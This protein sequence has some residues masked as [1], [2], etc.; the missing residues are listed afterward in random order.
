MTNLDL[1]Q[2]F[3]ALSDVVVN[4]PP[5]LREFDQIYMKISDMLL[6]AELVS[7][8]VD[9]KSIVCIGD[10][11]AIGLTLTHLMSEGIF[12][13]GP[14]HVHVLDFDER[15]VNSVETFAKNYQL[16]D[17]ITAELYNVADP[18][19][20]THIGKFDAFYTNPPFG[21]SNGGRSVE[22]FLQRGNEALAYRGMG[23]LVAATVN[24]SLPWTTQVMNR[25][26]MYLLENGYTMAEIV[27]QFHHY[28]LDDNPDLT[29]CSLIAV[30]DPKAGV[31]LTSAPLPTE[32]YQDFYGAC[33]P[34][35]V[36]YVRQV[37]EDCN[38][39]PYGHCFE[40]L[41]VGGTDDK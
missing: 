22:A 37:P 10:G 25:V 26:Q 7:R 38:S 27:P 13:R 17:S 39:P 20:K 31:H 16:Q 36:R 33:S 12:E 3:N 29:S 9:G 23:C 30:R 21:A 8:W 5:P 2:A 35:R 15:I 24:P 1:R 6:Q 40:F 19:P 11:D 34:L 18:L 28:H 41:P 32:V 4:R 14:K